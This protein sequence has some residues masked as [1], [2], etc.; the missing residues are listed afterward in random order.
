MSTKLENRKAA[1]HVRN[2][3]IEKPAHDP[4]R[5]VRSHPE[6]IER[7][8]REQKEIPAVE[9]STLKNNNTFSKAHERKVEPI[10][11]PRESRLHVV[12]TIPI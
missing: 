3:K 12:T 7:E 6:A 10:L 1:G 2:R 8:T 9:M 5:R 11:A 4:M